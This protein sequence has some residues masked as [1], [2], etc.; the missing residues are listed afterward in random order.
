MVKQAIIEEDLKLSIARLARD[1]KLVQKGWSM[2]KGV[3]MGGCRHSPICG[4]REEKGI[5]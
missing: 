1:K 4:K 2:I 5:A 3:Y